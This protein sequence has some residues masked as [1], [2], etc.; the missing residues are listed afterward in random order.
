MTI[1]DFSRALI[2]WEIQDWSTIEPQEDI[3]PS[4]KYF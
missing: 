4:E 1:H 2:I 3:C